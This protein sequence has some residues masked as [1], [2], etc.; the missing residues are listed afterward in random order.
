MK[1]TLQ[2]QLLRAA[3]FLLTPFESI[4]PLLRRLRY[5]SALFGVHEPRSD[6]IFIVSYPKSGTTMMQMMLYQLFTDGSLNISHISSVCPWFEYEYM[7]HGSD[8]TRELF[9]SL[10][11]PRVFK[12]HLHYEDLPRQGKFIYIARGV[13]DV[14][15]SFYHHRRLMTGR[16]PDRDRFMNR[17][18][19]T[20]TPMLSWFKN[21]ESWWP[22]RHDENV[23]FLTYE[24]ILK[25][26]E[27]T[28][29]KVA[30]FCKIEVDPGSMPRILE[31][32]S[33]GF[34]KQHWDKFDPRLHRISPSRTEFIRKGMVGAGRQELTPEQETLVSRRL[35]ALV[36]RLGCS[37]DD[38]Y[39][40]FFT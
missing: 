22:R 10:P 6:D 34:M 39:S 25:D 17:F 27:G 28:V 5:Q 1:K 21:L 37:P 16:D 19:R 32:C 2:A 20:R 12:S 38:P 3:I 14:M 31:R 4:E 7:N 30:A 33:L 23:L 40:E 26:L 36:A 11:S 18:L 15:V 8:S 35:Q 9:E 24:D 13:R 29:R